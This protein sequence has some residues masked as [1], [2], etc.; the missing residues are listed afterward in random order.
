MLLSAIGLSSRDDDRSSWFDNVRFPESQWKGV[1][2]HKW[3]TKNGKMTF[4]DE[5]ACNFRYDYSSEI[6]KKEIVVEEMD[7]NL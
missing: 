7:T 5:A 4:H 1:E 6:G 2:R 3:N